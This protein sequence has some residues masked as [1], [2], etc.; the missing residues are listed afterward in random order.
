[1]KI[2]TKISKSVDPYQFTPILGLQT[3]VDDK[4][5]FEGYFHLENGKDLKLNAKKEKLLINHIRNELKK[6]LTKDLKEVK[7]ESKIL[8]GTVVNS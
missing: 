6:L 3:T 1:M 8:S 4:I 7:Y 2:D 5:V